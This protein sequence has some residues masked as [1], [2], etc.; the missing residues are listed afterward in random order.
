MS[1]ISQIPTLSS[2]H[3][4]IPIRLEKEAGIAK[5]KAYSL[6]TLPE[7]V[8]RQYPLKLPP[9]TTQEKFDIAITEL[10]SLLREDGV[11]LNDKPL[12]DGWYME[13][14]YNL[15][16]STSRLTTSS[17]LFRNTHD[18]FHIANQE[19]LV[20]SAIAYPSS[21]TEVQNIVKWA[22]K[23]LMPIYPISLGR[24]LGYG[25]AAPRVPGSVV[26]DLGRKMN[27]VLKISGE[28]ASC[29]VEPGVSY[30]KLYENVQKSGGFSSRYTYKREP[31]R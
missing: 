18:A 9:N 12:V 30:F 4:G 3:S 13:H 15:P 6:R 16:Q 7:S 22:I 28:N 26:I 1:K 5:E 17:L 10:R 29:L 21:V 8:P 31:E 11:E 14:P 20:C 25:G 24:N 27:R 23:Y 19:E 2:S